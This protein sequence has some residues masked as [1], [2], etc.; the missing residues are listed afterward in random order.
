[1]NKEG[2]EASHTFFNQ[3]FNVFFVAG[4]DSAPKSNV[5]MK[6]RSD[7]CRLADSGRFNLFFKRLD[8]CGN[9][10]RIQWHI[11]QR[12]DPS[13]NRSF[14]R[15]IKSFPFRST[16]FIDVHMRIDNTRH[17]NFFTD[18]NCVINFALHY[19]FDQAIFYCYGSFNDSC[20]S[21]DSITMYGCVEH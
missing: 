4:N 12:C 7:G 2:F 18:V 10:R 6:F 14:S 19:L 15:R 21:H 5:A 9:W 1:M 16:R 20:R 13:R 3:R 11:N 8:C 17:Q